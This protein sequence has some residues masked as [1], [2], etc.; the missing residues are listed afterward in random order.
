[1]D[2][3]CY[4]LNRIFREIQVIE[5]NDFNFQEDQEPVDYVEKICENMQ[6]I[7]NS[8]TWHEREVMH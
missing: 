2:C 5:E 1:M 8:P 4:T 6:V 7:F 3:F